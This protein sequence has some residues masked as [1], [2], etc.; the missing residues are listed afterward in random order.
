MGLV[1][2][3]H[4]GILVPWMGIEPVSSALQGR[5]LNT[6]PLGKSLVS[7]LACCSL[8]WRC[9]CSPLQLEKHS[10][11]KANGTFSG[12]SFSLTSRY[13]LFYITCII[14][15]SLLLSI[16]EFLYNFLKF[17]T[18][19]FYLNQDLNLAL[20]DTKLVNIAT[21]THA[22]EVSGSFSGLPE[23]PCSV[24]ELI[25]FNCIHFLVRFLGRR[26]AWELL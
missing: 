20:S 24:R 21:R 16:S 22:T 9:P 2:L 10:F 6:G 5:F 12:M 18:T 26:T 23:H 14:K 25:S 19:S 15:F 13:I 4:V 1:T 11:V 3:R 17:N 7:P 8:Y